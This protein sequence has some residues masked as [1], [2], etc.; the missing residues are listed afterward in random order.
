MVRWALVFFMV[1][2]VA[3]VLGFGGFAGEAKVP[4]A[5]LAFL[6]FTLAGVSWVSSRA[7]PAP[8][9]GGY[10]GRRPPAG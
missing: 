5:A 1:A 10:A 4:V 3:A 6:C 7:L 8:S 2:L 9:A